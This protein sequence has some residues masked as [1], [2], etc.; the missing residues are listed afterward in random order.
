MQPSHAGVPSPH[1]RVEET[2]AQQGEVTRLE[3]MAELG[4][5]H[6][7][8]PKPSVK[9]TLSGGALIIASPGMIS[10]SVH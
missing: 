1:V 5:G 3:L 4:T 10:V 7:V 6:Q 8:S 2:E 9:Y